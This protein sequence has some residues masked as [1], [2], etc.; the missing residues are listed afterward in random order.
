MDF[1]GERATLEPELAR[2]LNLMIVKSMSK[3][4]GIGGLRL[5]YLATADLELA[6]RARSALP[7][8]NVNGLAEAFLRHLPAFAGDFRASVKLTRTEC[9]EL[10]DQLAE[11]PGVYAHPPDANFVLVRLGPGRR[12][13]DVVRA[14]LRDHRLF[15]KD[16]AGKSM[17]DGERYL[18]VA[19][20]T[21]SENAHF[22]GA[23]REVLAGVSAYP[24]AAG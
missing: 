22:A 16:C 4:Y 18:R 14:L 5:G 19:S 13:E 10:Y 1:C 9:D 8:W 21:S 24:V 23:L 20:R 7:I 15:V 3:A 11:I 17:R 12:S 6:A 2:F